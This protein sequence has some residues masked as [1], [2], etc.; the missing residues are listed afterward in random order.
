MNLPEIIGTIL[1]SIGGLGGLGWL[2][3]F[4]VERAVTQL[5]T[6]LS[7][8]HVGHLSVLEALSNLRERLA[9]I[10]EANKKTK[11]DLDEAH[12]RIRELQSNGVS[13]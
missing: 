13:E 3:K 9:V 6:Q 1:A 7:G 2:T 12:R 10:E 11:A 5:D 8:L 4:L